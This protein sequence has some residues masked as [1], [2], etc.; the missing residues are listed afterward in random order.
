[1][2]T[3]S[4]IKPLVQHEIEALPKVVGRTCTVIF[5]ENIEGPIEKEEGDQVYTYDRYTLETQYRE[6]LEE[7]IEKNREAWLQKAIKAEQEGEEQNQNPF[8]MDE[9]AYKRLKPHLA[10]KEGINSDAYKG[11]QTG[12]EYSDLECF[13]KV[14]RQLEIE[15]LIV[16]VPVNG[17]YYDFT[18]FPKEARQNYYEKVR[19]LA[20]SYGA[21]I[22]DFSDQ[23]YTKYFFEDRVHLGKKGWVMVDESLYEFY[24]EA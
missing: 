11:Y 7:S 15:P 10:K 13:L 2:R 19:T 3:E 9:S 22:A 6:N 21:K 20:E 4:N 18:G 17:Y 24:K 23:E 12:P 8:Y 14:C 5:Y 16:I 1:M